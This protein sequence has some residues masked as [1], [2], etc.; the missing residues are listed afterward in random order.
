M[1]SRIWG[2]LG[3]A[4]VAGTGCGRPRVIEGATYVHFVDAQS[5]YHGSIQGGSDYLHEIGS[6]SRYLGSFRGIDVRPMARM[7]MVPVR[8]V[9]AP[10]EGERTEPVPPVEPTPPPNGRVEPPVTEPPPSL[11]EGFE[12]FC[13]AHP[14]VTVT[15]RRDCPVCHSPLQTRRVEEEP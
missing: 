14:G 3:M 4:L 7:M 1:R 2:L 5:P 13:P 6:E 8:P 11:P 12:H 10:P 9:S 15:G